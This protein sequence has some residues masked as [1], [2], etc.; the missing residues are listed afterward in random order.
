[1]LVVSGWLRFDPA[2]RE[3]IARA[4]VEVTEQSRKDEGCVDYWW[5][6]D[7]AEPGTFRFFEC[8]ESEE[9]FDAHRTQP[10]EERFMAEVVSRTTGVDAH[11]YEIAARSSAM[12]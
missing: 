1:M 7:V 3:E 4:L 6:E 9:L 12:G 10:Y 11:R 8:W 5:A 2:A